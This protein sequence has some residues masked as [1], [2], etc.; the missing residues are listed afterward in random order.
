MVDRA[1]RDRMAQALRLLVTGKSTIDAFDEACPEDCRDA[2]VPA[3]WSFGCMFFEGDPPALTPRDWRQAARLLLFLSTDV[4]YRW[5]PEGAN[6]LGGCGYLGV[7]VVCLYVSLLLTCSGHWAAQ[8]YTTAPGL[9][10]LVLAMI[11]TRR[12]SGDLDVWP[13][14][15]RDDYRA[16]LRGRRG[17]WSR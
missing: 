15:R 5:A 10:A 6:V 1:A 3:A 7:G 4:E 12:S 11:W 2:A 9:L 17:R 14:Q 13:F 16:A 8:W